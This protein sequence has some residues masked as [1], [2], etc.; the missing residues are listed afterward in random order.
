MTER[1]AGRVTRFW[2]ICKAVRVQRAEA[3]PILTRTDRAR[4]A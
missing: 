3:E 2:G 4:V 1:E